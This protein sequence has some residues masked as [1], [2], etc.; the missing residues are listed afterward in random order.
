MKTG[1]FI[2]FFFINTVSIFSQAFTDTMYFDLAWEQT[3]KENAKYYRTII[4][5]NSG[6][7]LFHVTDYYLSGQA[8]MTGTYRSIRPDN[9]EGT[10]TWYF[11]NGRKQQECEYKNNIL[12][13]VF[14]EWYENGQ[15]KLRQS[16][17]E[18]LFDGP[19][20]TWK[21][22]GTIELEAQ[23][24][25]GEKHGYFITYFDNGQMIRKD[26]YEHGILIEGQC[27]NRDGTFAEYF[28]YIVSPR[29]TGGPSELR[30]Y[31]EKNLKY[32]K[33]AEKQAKE[34]VILVIFTV[35]ETGKVK[36]PQIVH[37]DLDSFN[38]EALRLVASFPAW[39]P[40]LIDGRP[41]TLQMSIPI[42]FR[43]Q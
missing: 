34:A 42:E 30:K 40:G 1:L 17:Y 18:G 27:F 12:H 3:I 4:T 5:D 2:Y 41:C 37:G 14:Q 15:P 20:K 6:D 28:P 38:E 32:P 19:V 11:P 23:Y 24:S 39:I 33:I 43:L 16:R 31:I 26:L 35:D 7:F 25:K 10:F 21:Q 29:F 36:D 13:G 22:D 8:Q 9:R